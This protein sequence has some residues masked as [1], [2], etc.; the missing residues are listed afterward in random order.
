MTQLWTVKVSDVNEQDRLGIKGAE[1][2]LLFSFYPLTPI[3]QF[4]CEYF[5]LS[6]KRIFKACDFSLFHLSK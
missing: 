6:L 5:S 4:S 2:M 3:S 1:E